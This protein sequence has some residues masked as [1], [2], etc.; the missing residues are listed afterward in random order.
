MKKLLFLL[1]LTL[2]CP[3]LAQVI[4]P[5]TPWSR[6]FMRSANQE[7]AL[8]VLGLSTNGT[9]IAFASGQFDTTGATVAIKGGAGLTNPAIA[10]IV[11]NLA[12]RG[13]TNGTGS[14]SVI[15]DGSGLTLNGTNGAQL[16]VFASNRAF[17]IQ[18]TDTNAA[19]I[20]RSGGGLQN[21]LVISNGMVGIAKVPSESAF[22][23]SVAGSM[24]AIYNSRIGAGFDFYFNGRSRISSPSDG[25]LSLANYAKSSLTRLHLGPQSNGFP[26]LSVTNGGLVVTDKDGVTQPSNTLTAA[27]FYA[28]T[29]ATN[30]AVNP[31]GKVNVA[32]LATGGLGTLANPYTNWIVIQTNSTHYLLPSGYYTNTHLVF[33]CSNSPLTDITLEG[34]E[35]T[36]LLLS[37]SPTAY[38][39][40][41]NSVGG[42][43]AAP[44][45][46]GLAFINATP[47][48]Y[49]N[50][51][52]ITL[53][54]LIID[55]CGTAQ[56]G[57]LFSAA[58]NIRT[59]NVVV[60]NCL[61]DH[62]DMFSCWVGTHDG[63]TVPGRFA[64]GYKGG[65]NGLIID[66][67]DDANWSTCQTF[68][69]A[70]I[71]D[72]TNGITLRAATG[73]I[74]NSGT[75][76]FNSSNGVQ[77]L[78][79]TATPA[80]PPA[81]NVFNQME[82]GANAAYQIYD[83][84]G[85]VNT[86][87]KFNHC[88]RSGGLGDYWGQTSDILVDLDKTIYRAHARTTIGTN[89]AWALTTAANPFSGAAYDTGVHT[90]FKNGIYNEGTYLSFATNGF[91]GIGFASVGEW[92]IMFVHRDG[93][94]PGASF[95][96][97]IC[98]TRTN[99]MFVFGVTQTN[100]AAFSDFVPKLSIGATITNLAPT[101]FNGGITAKGNAG[102]TTN[103][104]TASQITWTVTDGI[105]TGVAY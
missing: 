32:Q 10:G 74:F 44:I 71:Q 80:Q 48:V 58:H 91:T 7:T 65:T 29:G 93:W 19:L 24:D 54:N 86:Y 105:I 79:S 104:T 40:M 72:V 11:T 25:V 22:P 27:K 5:S 60:R 101:V 85:S 64:T 73:C 69:G 96:D 36:V 28:Q 82:I 62:I 46:T 100:G 20:F 16:T 68:N 88:N 34:E 98:Q 17:Y 15:L 45:G 102:L 31:S 13:L 92:P 9:N 63:L 103:F 59:E 1:A 90:V 2:A 41:T 75:S 99:N 55:G 67:I 3:A 26:A 23:L 37:G 78:P 47:D 39:G 87:N 56:A 8:G 70:L 57:L 35:G 52:R 53:R 42:A 21:T 4:I 97:I 18:S 30:L 61:G 89:C 51:Q 76:E 33:Y 14:N 50:M 77:L 66:G 6:S 83:D 94:M 43:I 84:P 12:T 49:T 95:A 81:G 38:L